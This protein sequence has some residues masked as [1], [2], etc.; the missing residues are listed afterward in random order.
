[1]FSNPI[2]G[3]TA[4]A[5]M[6]HFS[7]PRTIKYKKIIIIINQYQKHAQT[8]FLFSYAFLKLVFSTTSFP[9]QNIN[10]KTT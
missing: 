9:C 2:E 6:Q 5:N 3:Q 10:K 4:I 8:C 7:T 1:V